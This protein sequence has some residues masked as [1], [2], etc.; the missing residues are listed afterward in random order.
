LLQQR[1]NEYKNCVKIFCMRYNF[2]SAQRHWKK[3]GNA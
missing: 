2:F 1:E 3:S